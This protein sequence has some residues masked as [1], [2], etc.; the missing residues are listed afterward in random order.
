MNAQEQNRLP[1]E[2]DTRIVTNLVLYDNIVCGMPCWLY[3]F[4][5]VST[6]SASN[7]LLLLNGTD[8]AGPAV[9][10]IGALA[11]TTVPVFLL[12]PVRFNKGIYVLKEAGGGYL[13]A[14]YKPDY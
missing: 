11:E 10:R 4:I 6:A 2:P 3:S 12:N 9:I 14:Q 13:F 7:R 5:Y 8:A 1:A